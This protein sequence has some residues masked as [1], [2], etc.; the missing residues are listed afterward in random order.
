MRQTVYLDVLVAV[1]FLVDY[2]LLYAAGQLSASAI[3]RVRLCLGALLGAA[4]SCSILLP[5]LPAALN[6]LIT[7]GSCALMTLT[8]FGFSGWRRFARSM[9]WVAAVTAGYGGLM[10]ALWLLAEPRGL[11][12]NNGAVYIDIPPELLVLATVVCYA[13]TSL[14][15]GQM[16][17]RN[18]MRS[19]CR[20]TITNGGS[21]VSLDAIVDTG[22]LLT[23][24]FSG[25]PVIVAEREALQPV[26]PEG[27]DS[28]DKSGE[29]SAGQSPPGF[30]VVPYSGVGGKGIMLAFRPQKITTVL[31]GGSPRTAEAYIGV[32]NGGRVGREHRAIVNPD[33]LL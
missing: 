8:A 14:Y 33:I 17:K 3:S 18:L 20:V 27:F 23:E 24:P 6:C 12:I 7:I 25:L 32:L 1:N 29:A 21:Q 2:F 15:S 30:R 11:I 4:C 13:I 19:R 5:P 10:L 16:R 9:L 26:L 22:N 31:P 28:F